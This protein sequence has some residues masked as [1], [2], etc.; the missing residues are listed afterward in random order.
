MHRWGP[1]AGYGITESA[2]C[3]ELATPL[4]NLRP[5]NIVTARDIGHHRPWRKRFAQ[6]PELV[7]LSPP[8]P[9]H[10]ARHQLRS[11]PNFRPKRFITDVT[12]QIP[13]D[14]V[15]RPRSAAYYIQNDPAKSAGNL[16]RPTRGIQCGVSTPL[17][18]NQLVRIFLS[19]NN[20]LEPI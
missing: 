13:S 11:H 9:P 20:T 2:P 3:Q 7:F 19:P 14:A 10:R 15:R 16:R 4:V 12:S 18:I 6:N 5:T 17:S 1:L 8:P